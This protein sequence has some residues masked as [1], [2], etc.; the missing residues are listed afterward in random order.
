MS[1]KVSM[2]VAGIAVDDGAPEAR[3]PPALASD[4]TTIGADDRE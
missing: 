1:E 2:L 3:S 4:E